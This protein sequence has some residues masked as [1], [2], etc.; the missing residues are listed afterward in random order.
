MEEFG[1]GV[2]VVDSDDGEVEEVGGLGDDGGVS[3]CSDEDEWW[4]GHWVCIG[5]LDVWGLV[6]AIEKGSILE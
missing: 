2:V 3:A 6:C 1:A 4:G 5:Y